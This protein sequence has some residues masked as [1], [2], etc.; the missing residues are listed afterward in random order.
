MV[1]VN[2]RIMNRVTQWLLKRYF[3]YQSLIV[4]HVHPQT[5]FGELYIQDSS[6]I[7]H[8]VTP[9]LGLCVFDDVYIDGCEFLGTLTFD[10]TAN[11]II[12]GAK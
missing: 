11:T 12:K 4:I 6:I 2:V 1:D 5:R 7:I 8:L 9:K 10:T 3:R